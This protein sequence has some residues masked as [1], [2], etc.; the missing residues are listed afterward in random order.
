MIEYSLVDW[1]HWYQLYEKNQCHHFKLDFK[2]SA[3]L[4][5]LVTIYIHNYVF[6][7]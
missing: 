4:S 6:Y 1:D 3:F 5:K 2:I 7:I